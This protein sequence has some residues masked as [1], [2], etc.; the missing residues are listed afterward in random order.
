MRTLV[1]ISLFY[2]Q[3]AKAFLHKPVCIGVGTEYEGWIIPDDE[4]Y[5]QTSK[6]SNKI[7]EC[8]AIGSHLEGWY[9]FEKQDVTLLQR[10][11]C[12]F[13]IEQ[14]TCI[15]IGT[16]NEGWVI[17]ARG[18]RIYYQA[19]AGKGI[20][21]AGESFTTE[22]WYTFNKKPLGLYAYSNCGQF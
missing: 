16:P 10:S 15:F 21:C 22:G 11:P 17:P 14:P 3:T 19:C 20:D 8:G 7:M 4:N 13:E 9:V 2:F 18:M 5:I 1:L 12:R 6:C